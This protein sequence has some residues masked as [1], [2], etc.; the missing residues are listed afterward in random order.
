MSVTEI[1]VTGAGGEYM[2][3]VV[4]RAWHKKPGEPVAQGETVVTIETAKAA[5]DIEAP[6]SGVLAE[7]RVPTDDEVPIGAV[8]GIIADTMAEPPKQADAPAIPASEQPRCPEPSPEAAPAAPAPPSSPLTSAPVRVPCSPLARRIAAAAGVKLADI[9]CPARGR[10]RAADVQAFLA[11]RKNTSAAPLPPGQ[12]GSGHM[13]YATQPEAAPLVVFIHG[14]GGDRHGW[15]PLLRCLDGSFRTLTL[16]LPGH[17]SN[18]A[19]PSAY[20]IGGLADSIAGLLTQQDKGAI[21]LVGH[22]LGGAVA[23]LLA[24]DPR[25]DVRSLTLLAPVG[26]GP[27]IDGAFINGF[28]A[29]RQ[30]AS[31]APWLRR[32][33]HDPSLV[34]DAFVNATVRARTDSTVCEIQQHIASALFPDGT[35]ANDLR[36]TLHR[37]AVPTKVIWGESDRIIPVQH[38]RNAG[39]MAAVHFLPDTGHLP[40]LETPAMV[41]HLLRQIVRS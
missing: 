8:L 7:I 4:V 32:L 15:N 13:P 18:K 24:A 41:A 26:L 39:P 25:L 36:A 20:D 19:S 27:E 23:I 17:G 38:A 30:A 40:H 28:V 22:S 37:L 29:A 2:E 14:F 21:H 6:A 16:E 33:V 1:T 9:P 3:A 5:T 35:Q 11:T 31:I 34:T 12:A 10:I